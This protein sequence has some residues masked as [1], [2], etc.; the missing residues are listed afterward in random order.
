M[1][2]TNYEPNFAVTETEAPTFLI[3]LAILQASKPVTSTS[4][5]SLFLPYML[6]VIAES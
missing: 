2:M 5:K 1:D 4:P 3:S 6:S